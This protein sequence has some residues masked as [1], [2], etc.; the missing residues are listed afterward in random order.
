MPQASGHGGRRRMPRREDK[1]AGWSRSWGRRTDGAARS[2]SWLAATISATSSGTAWLTRA[3]SW[4]SR[5]GISEGYVLDQGPG[6]GGPYHQ[7]ARPWPTSPWRGQTG[8]SVRR[9][10]VTLR[11]RCSPVLD[12]ACTQPSQP[13]QTR[14]APLQPGG[15]HLIAEP[16]DIKRPGASLATIPPRPR[17]CRRRSRFSATTPAAA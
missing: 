17:R 13:P 3:A 2:R 8:E 7:W 5:G 10:G 9:V 15:E 12:R 14:E 1:S 4:R 16:A 11:L 6:A